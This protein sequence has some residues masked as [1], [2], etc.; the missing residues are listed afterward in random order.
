MADQEREL[1]GAEQARK[2]AFERTRAAYE[3][4]GY[5]YRPLVISVIAANVG[6][7]ALALPLDILLG[8]GFFL[9]HPEGSF[10]FDLLGSLLVL[11]AFVAL[12]LVHELIHGLVWGICAKRHWKAVSFGV[13]WKYLTPYC[14][15]DEPLSRRATS[16]ARSRPPSCSASCRWPS[17]TPPGPSS[18]WESGCS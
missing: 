8:I 10:A 18:G 15:C 13:I 9:L 16:Q 12:I 14:T 11:V 4:Q 6:A 1:T 3:A 2:E 17:R 7:V 5:R